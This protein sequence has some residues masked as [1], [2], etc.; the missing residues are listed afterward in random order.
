M[1]KG[2]K[3]VKGGNGVELEHEKQRKSSNNTGFL[4]V[5]VAYRGLLDRYDEIIARLGINDYIRQMRIVLA[6]EANEC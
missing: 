3:G 4:A 1:A 6:Y 5:F 2:S